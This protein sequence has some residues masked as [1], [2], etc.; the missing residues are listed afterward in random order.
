MQKETI[1]VYNKLCILECSSIKNKST[2][3]LK[4]SSTAIS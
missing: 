1:S 4:H 3:V 2:A